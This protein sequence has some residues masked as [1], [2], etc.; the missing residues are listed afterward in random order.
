MIFVLGGVTASEMRC[1][2]EVCDELPRENDAHADEE[3]K[4][5][6]SWFSFA[7]RGSSSLE[8]LEFDVFIGSTHIA[9]PVDQLNI[10][11]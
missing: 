2:Y 7:T 4:S 11:V 1:A 8:L 3:A 10:F 5:K 6:K 9:E